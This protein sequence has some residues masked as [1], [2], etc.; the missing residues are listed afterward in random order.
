MAIPDFLYVWTPDDTESKQCTD[1]SYYMQVYKDPELKACLDDRILKI[2]AAQEDDGYLY[3][4]RTIDPAKAADGGGEG[5]WTSLPVHHELC[6]GFLAGVSFVG[7]SFFYPNPL[8]SDGFNK[9]NQGVCGRSVWL[10]LK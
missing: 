9:Y 6:N 3:T 1:A 2:A 4:N 10:D 5:R 7:N 8:E